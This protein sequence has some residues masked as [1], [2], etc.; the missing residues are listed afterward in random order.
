MQIAESAVIAQ[1]KGGC[2]AGSGPDLTGYPHLVYAPAQWGEGV[3]CGSNGI[4]AA[5]VASDAKHDPIGDVAEAYGVS[6]QEVCD[7]VRYAKA[8]GLI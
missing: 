4:P 5:A 6:L 8:H 1:L 2:A 3:R 7:C